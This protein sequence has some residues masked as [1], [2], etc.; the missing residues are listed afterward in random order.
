MSGGAAGTGTRP[1]TLTEA[2]A[3]HARHRPDGMAI[4][5]QERR[6]TFRELHERGNRTAH[7][8]LAEGLAPGARVGYLGRDSE[9][10]YEALL[11][12]ARTGAVLVPVDP[13]LTE[14]ELAHVLRD[15]QAALLLAEEDR[16]EAVDRIRSTLPELRTV[17]PLCADA[18]GGGFPGWQ[19]G[20]PD[21]DLPGVTRSRDPL[22]QIYTSG[23]TGA[24]K[25]VV[26]RQGSFWAVN[27]L[28][29]R[30]RLDWLDWREDDRSLNLLPGHH[31]GGPWWFLQGFRAGATNVL[32]RDFQGQHTLRLIRDSG[33]TTTLMVPAMLQVLLSEPGVSPADFTGLRKVVYG[34]SP[35]PESLLRRCLETMRCEFAQIYGLTETCASAVCL[36]PA[37]HVPGN[38]RLAAAGRPY[39]GV[40]VQ[41]VDDAGNPLPTGQV[42][43]VL[44]DTPAVMDGYW[45]RPR[46]SAL[47]VADGWLRT[48]DAGC[49]DDDGYLY[50]RDRIKDV[51]L[52]AG[53]NVYPAEVEN[54]LRMCPAVA[55]AA[56]VGRPDRVRGEAVHAYVVPRAGDR[57]DPRELRE[58]LHGRLAEYKMPTAYEFVERLPR[59]VSGKVLRRALRARD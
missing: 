38:P 39:P 14:Q 33:I 23:T 29:A 45:Q 53:E 26:L 8:L 10:Y 24:P 52:V 30:H 34:G 43:E 7:G 21:T 6:V 15:S 5:C 40:A 32:V 16:L 47:T 51:I 50:I 55:D 13:R 59:N 57:P 18:P 2:A 12:C 37:D 4:E 44:I 31:I 41:I 22:V 1:T 35:I 20:R 11:A 42:G 48:G 19:A 27:D 56:V 54:A 25:G 17:L 28:L 49:V 3:H 58:F 46:E 9:Y 36:P